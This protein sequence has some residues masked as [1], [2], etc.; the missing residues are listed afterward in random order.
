MPGMA[1]MVCR[2]VENRMRKVQGAEM[3]GPCYNPETHEDCPSR[4]PGCAAT[5]ELWARYCR[6]RDDRYDSAIRKPI[7]TIGGKKFREYKA[8]ERLRMRK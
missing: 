3:S 8:R 1:R 7:L 6:E 2:S 5:C 4:G